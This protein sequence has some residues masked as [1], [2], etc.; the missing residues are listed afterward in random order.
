MMDPDAPTYRTLKE[1]WANLSADMPN[2]PDDPAVR[3][4]L[5][6]MFILGATAGVRLLAAGRRMEDLATEIDT[7]IAALEPTS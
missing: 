3:A 7:N 5:E 6:L 2:M 4:L 1:A